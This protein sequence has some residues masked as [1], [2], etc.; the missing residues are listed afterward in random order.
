M[1]WMNWSETYVVTFHSRSGWWDN[2]ENIF[3]SLEDALNFA[4]ISEPEDDEYGREFA[5]NFFMI[6]VEG[7][8]SGHRFYS[9]QF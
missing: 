6:T 9:T 3:L 1:N 7:L 2:I 5:S 8:E 4:E